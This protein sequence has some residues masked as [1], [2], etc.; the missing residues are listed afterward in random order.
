[1]RVKKVGSRVRIPLRLRLSA[2]WEGQEFRERSSEPAP[3]SAPVE[4]P[5]RE[6]RELDRLTL[7]Q[8]IWGKGFNGPEAKE[9]LLHLVNPFGLTSSATV[10]QLGAGLGGAARAMVEAFGCRVKALEPAPELGRRGFGTVVQR[11]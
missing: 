4:P 9:F 3:P 7:T 10:V 5:V 2:W 6:R 1:M 11:R 8:A